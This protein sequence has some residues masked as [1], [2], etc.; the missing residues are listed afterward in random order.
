MNATGRPD[1]RARANALRDRVLDGPGETAPALRQAV[2]LSAAGGSPAPPPYDA[3][4]RQIG[5]AAHR[6]TDADVA[7][8][9]RMTGSERATF[10]VILAAA[11]GAGLLRWQKAL[12]VLDEATDATS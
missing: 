2:A 3:L 9:V 5:E 4:A 12:T 11:V 10:E 1:H 8:V 7:N 6:T